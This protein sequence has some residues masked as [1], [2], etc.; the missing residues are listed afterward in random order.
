MFNYS[1]SKTLLG[2]HVF[3]DSRTWGNRDA[4]PLPQFG[5]TRK[6][7]CKFKTA[8]C[9]SIAIFSFCLI[10]LLS[11]LFHK[12]WSQKPSLIEFLHGNYLR[13]CCLWNSY[14]MFLIKCSSSIYQLS[15]GRRDPS[16]TFRQTWTGSLLGWFA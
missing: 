3:S 8:W 9:V 7:H 14:D 5:I 2:W 4:V 12:H 1:R 6:D 13:I 16:N 10:W 11:L 15:Q